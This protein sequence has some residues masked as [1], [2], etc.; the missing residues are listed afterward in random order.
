MKPRLRT[1]LTALL[2][3]VLALMVWGRLRGGSE[4]RYRYGTAPVDRGDITAF[5]T[6]TG[7]VNPTVTYRVASRVEGTVTEVLVDYN[8]T[9]KKGQPLARLDAEP[10]RRKLEMARADLKHARAE[11]ELLRKTYA[12]NKELYAE[13]FISSEELQNSR[14]RHLSALAQVERA[15][16]ALKTAEADLEAATIRSPIDGTVIS[17]NVKPGQSVSPSLAEPLFIVAASTSRMEVEAN[18]SEADIGLVE[19]GQ[20]ARF[21]V[22][23]YPDTEFTGTVSTIIND[24]VVRDNVVT[25]NVIVAVDNPEGKLRPGMTAAVRLLVAQRRGVLRVPNAALRFIPPP[26]AR[27]RGNVDGDGG[28]ARVVWTEV[29]R[30]ELVPVKVK[31][32]ISDER[33]TELVE[34][35]GLKEGD[36]VV[37]EAV[38]EGTAG[39]SDPLGPIR[40]PQPKRF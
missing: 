31:A 23:A 1:A 28:G 21:T 29:G 11:A 37:V 30:D 6:A 13:G 25:Y 17:V 14:A 5:V 12:A 35:D 22:D 40:L 7:T 24:P 10:F 36:R 27:I 15:E 3:V 8:S 4:L 18:V 32:G 16:T 20:K 33:Y 34:A 2:V 39:S 19:V 26:A 38:R 9:V